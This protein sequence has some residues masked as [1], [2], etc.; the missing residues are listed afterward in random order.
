MINNSQ[1]CNP[2]ETTNHHF[3]NTIIE[4]KDDLLLT[5]K[6][7]KKLTEMYIPIKVII[8]LNSALLNPQPC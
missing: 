3:A 4:K 6:R 2:E 8:V 1:S 5:K 7:K